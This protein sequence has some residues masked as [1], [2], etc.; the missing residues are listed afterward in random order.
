VRQALTA[1]AALA[2]IDISVEDFIGLAQG[3]PRRLQRVR[4]I[5]FET[6]DQ[7]LRPLEASDQGSHC[8][9]PV[10]IKNLRKGDGA[11]HMHKVLLGWVV[12]SQA[13]TIELTMAK[14]ER[15][16]TILQ[17]PTDKD[18]LYQNSG[19]RSSANSGTLL[20]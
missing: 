20:M 3:G 11:C 6:V 16:M 12:D 5:L 4:Q 17:I 14:A 8:T 13:L 15:L 10:S 19:N 2:S 1:R 7:V 9:E 18:A